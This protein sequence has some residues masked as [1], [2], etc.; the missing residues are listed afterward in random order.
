MNW[1][2]T[3]FRCFGD[4][5]ELYEAYHDDEWGRPV[6]DAQHMLERLCLEGFQAGLA[7]VTILR[8]RENFRAAFAGFDPAKVAKFTAKDQARL[9]EDA[10]IVR[11]R[12]KIEAT[13]ANAQAAL[14]NSRPTASTSLSSSGR[15][16]RTRRRRRARR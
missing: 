2:V 3:P 9:M 6:T 4:G 12:L 15:T 10:G 16:R 13:I 14:C 1:A 7:W 5:N 11:N 8:K